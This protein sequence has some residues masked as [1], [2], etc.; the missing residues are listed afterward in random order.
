ASNRV[1]IMHTLRTRKPRTLGIVLVLA[2]GLWTAT[3]VVSRAY[4]TYA[5]W[6]PAQATFY[7][8]PQNLYVSADAAEQ[9]LITRAMAWQNQTPIPFRYT[10]GGRVNDTTT[11]YDGR[12][13]VIFRNESN[14]GTIASTYSWWDSSNHLVDSDTIWY[15][16]GFHYY[17]GTSGCLEGGILNSLYIEDAATHE[18]G[19]MLGMGHSS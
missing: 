3:E 14:G 4:T 18:F 16:Q 11:G 8:N 12:N 5:S 1:T 15:E 13:V 2:A 6:S 17:T 19:H 9:A 7:V 10:Y